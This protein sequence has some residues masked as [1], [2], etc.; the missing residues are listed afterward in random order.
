[1]ELS[2]L[3]GSLRVGWQ[4]RSGLESG[5]VKAGLV[6]LEP[7]VVGPPGAGLKPGSMGADLLLY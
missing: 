4:T 2:L 6:D 1:M 7:G 5:A 3:P